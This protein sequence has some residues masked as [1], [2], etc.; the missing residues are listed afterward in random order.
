MEHVLCYKD[1]QRLE[2]PFKFDRGRKAALEAV[3]SRWT[4]PENIDFVRD[5][6]NKRRL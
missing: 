2:E 5:P 3:I 6:D 4:K 1:G